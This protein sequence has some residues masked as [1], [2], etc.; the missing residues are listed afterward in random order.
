MKKTYWIFFFILILILVFIFNIKNNKKENLN[1][2]NKN[3]LIKI[4]AVLALTGDGSTY[5]IAIKN[6]IELAKTELEKSGKFQDKKI[7]IIYEDGRLQALPSLN[8]AKKL[9][10]IDKV[11]FI[12]GAVFSEDS[13]AIAPYINKN[14]VLDFSFGSSPDITLAGDYVFRNFP[15]DKYYA[16]SLFKI[17]KKY[18]NIAILSENSNDATGLKKI[19]LDEI[20]K[21]K[22]ILNETFNGN[23]IDYS[24][25]VLK[26]KDKNVD[27]IIIIPQVDKTLINIFKK[28][29]EYKISG[30]IYTPWNLGDTLKDLDELYFVDLPDINNIKNDKTKSFIENYKQTY[31]NENNILWAAFGYDGF[32]ILANSVLNFNQDVDKVKDAILNIKDYAG[33]AGTY[34]FDKNGDAI[35]FDFI[36]KKVENK[37]FKDIEKIQ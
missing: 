8:A 23:I 36:L 21:S 1:N 6:G 4:G 33:A 2:L 11:K 37:S 12:L 20:D 30:D 13:L 27:M 35:G 22:I 10:E 31:K 24:Q 17:S 7:K 28:I 32:N 15:S 3:N 14:K 18:K 16:D 25:V 29:K 9:V 26:L 5:G 34:T 19:L